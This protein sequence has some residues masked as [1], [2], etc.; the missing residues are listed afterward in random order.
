[1]NRF[2]SASL[3]AFVCTLG[4][5]PLAPTPEPGES[6]AVDLDL[7]EWCPAP[8]TTT[9]VEEDKL[10][11]QFTEDARYCAVSAPGTWDEENYVP[12]WDTLSDAMQLQLVPGDHFLPLEAG[13]YDVRAPLCARRGGTEGIAPRGDASLLVDR[14]TSVGQTRIIYV[15][16]Q[17]V[18]R[19][20]GRV[21]TVRL[22]FSGFDFML[23]GGLQLDGR[24]L[25]RGGDPEVSLFVCDGD[26]CEAPTDP[27]AEPRAQ[28]RWDAC[29]YPDEGTQHYTITF[30][31]GRLE[32]DLEH[33]GS[34]YE[35]RD[36]LVR[37]R[38]E[39]LGAAFDQTSFWRMTER[40]SYPFSYSRD[41]AVAFDSPIGD[42]CGISVRQ[43]SF[44]NWVQSLALVPCNANDEEQR[45][46]FT[47][48]WE[49]TQPEEPAPGNP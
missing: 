21:M 32:L 9:R 13:E 2:A 8:E 25:P 38:G 28:Q 42:Y 48:E 12:V 20:D 30:D 5:A 39:L 44:G 4:C 47:V 41:V 45:T 15:L 17:P 36:A 6:L 29:R 24:P 19:E 27:E 35:M 14:Q 16:E 10:W 49:E 33:E 34:P 23:E 40:E 18:T 11:L 37:A 46:V 31:G 26:T 1:M 7:W 3:A 22:Q 43:M